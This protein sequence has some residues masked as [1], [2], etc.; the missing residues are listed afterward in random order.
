MRAEATRLCLEA[1][2]DHL[3]EWLAEVAE[4]AAAGAGAGGEPGGGFGAAAAAASATYEEW[5]EALHPENTHAGALLDLDRTID[6]RFY[7]VDSDHRL[8]WNALAVPPHRPVEAINPSRPE[9]SLGDVDLLLSLI[10]IS[11]PTRPY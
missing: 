9:Q 6:H 11:E 10:H 8:L 2:R 3:V 1:T 4:T 5:V 7:V